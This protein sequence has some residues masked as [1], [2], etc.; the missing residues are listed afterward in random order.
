[1]K[2]LVPKVKIWLASEEGDGTFGGG[3]YRLLKAINELGSLSAAAEDMK[4]SYRKAWGDLKK[5]EK[6][7]DCC[8]MHKERGGQGGGRTTL[9][10]EGKELVQQ[11][12]ELTAKVKGFA[13]SCHS[14]G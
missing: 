2:K 8:L 4:I 9:T 13:K 7:L 5:A 11:Y 1:M 6:E 14:E 12:E 3:K 10:E